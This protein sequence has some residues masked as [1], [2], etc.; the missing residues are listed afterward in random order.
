MDFYVEADGKF[1][2]CRYQPLSSVRQDTTGGLPKC[3]RSGKRRPLRSIRIAKQFGAEKGTSGS[4]AK[5][6]PPA[7]NTVIGQFWPRHVRQCVGDTSTHLS[8]H[9][10][11]QPPMP[12]RHVNKS[13]AVSPSSITATSTF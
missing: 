12:R 13:A 8:V 4:Y 6:T 11:I 3:T 7:A 2:W 1:P 5:V 9:A 10:L